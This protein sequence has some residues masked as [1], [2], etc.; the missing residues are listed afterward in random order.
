MISF[1]KGK[2]RRVTEIVVSEIIANDIAIDPSDGDRV[3]REIETGLAECKNT[4]RSLQI[5]FRNLRLV[6]SSFL[7]SAIGTLYRD[8]D[9]SR[10]KES[11]Q[12]TDASP[13]DLA[14]VQRVVRHAREYFRNPSLHDRIAKTVMDE[15]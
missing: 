2:G 4:A 10:L 3:R 5:S 14:L 12:I 9:A 6:T 11:L 7:N 13:E 1:E 15:D 8:Y